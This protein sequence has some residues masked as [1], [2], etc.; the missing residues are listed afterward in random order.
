M[1][2]V[3][4]S[5]NEYVMLCYV[6]HGHRRMASTVDAQH[7]AVKTAEAI[8]RLTA[9]SI[10]VLPSSVVQSVMYNVT[11]VLLLSSVNVTTQLM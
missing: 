9:H 6:R 11:N 10:T 1:R 2:H 7:R 4:F 8:R 3:I 5:L